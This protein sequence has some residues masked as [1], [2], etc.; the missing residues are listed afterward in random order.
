MSNTQRFRQAI[1]GV[2]G[3]LKGYSQSFSAK[4]PGREWEPF[5][6]IEG[7]PCQW[8]QVD[9]LVGRAVEFK[10]MGPRKMPLHFH[11]SPEIVVCT[12]GQVEFTVEGYS[13]T[14]KAGDVINIEGSQVHSARFI[15]LATV[16]VW[17]TKVESE[18]LDIQVLENT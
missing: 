5:D 17:W 6:P 12:H 15:G 2:Y 16:V 14:L 9:S 4:L 10:S 18:F 11:D 8:R 1:R 3:V 13:H 7:G